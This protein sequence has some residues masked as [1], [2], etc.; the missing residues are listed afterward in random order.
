M[1]FKNIISRKVFL[2]EEELL[3]MT[4]T[5]LQLIENR[6]E[7]Y[8]LKE[9]WVTIDKEWTVCHFRCCSLLLRILPRVYI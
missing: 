1:F 9:Q 4:I 5:N 3:Y 7:G 6:K 8:R 2:I